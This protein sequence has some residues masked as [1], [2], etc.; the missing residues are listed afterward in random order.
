M[1]REKGLDVKIVNAKKEKIKDISEYDL[2]VVGSGMGDCRYT[3]E[4]EDFLK[5]FRKEFDGKKLALFVSTM[6]PFWERE[7]KTDDVAKTRKIGLE[8]K[9]AK[10]GLKPIALGFFGGVIDYGRMGFIARKGMEFFKP[11]LEKDGFKV[12]PDVYDL[13]NWDEIRNWASGLAEKALNP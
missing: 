10:Y 7:G 2:V 8:E 5:T 11:R 3:S 13:R 9:V 6:I 1:L 4:A 12:A